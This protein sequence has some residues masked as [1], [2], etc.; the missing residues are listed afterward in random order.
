MTC[1]TSTLTHRFWPHIV[2]EERGP[3]ARRHVWVQCTDPHSTLSARSYLYE[4]GTPVRVRVSLLVNARY[5]RAGI[6][7]ACVL[8][9]A[10]IYEIYI[11]RLYSILNG[12]MDYGIWGV[13]AKREGE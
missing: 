7:S 13:C 12:H 9:G 3:T 11:K 6:A 10:D 2:A 5:I 8:C 1:Q 4:C